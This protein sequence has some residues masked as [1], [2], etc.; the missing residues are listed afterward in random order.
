MNELKELFD[1]IKELDSRFKEVEDE[2]EKILFIILNIFYEF[3]LVGKDDIENVEV[4]C[5]GDVRV[6]DFEVKLYWEI[7]M[8]FGILDFERVLKVLGSCFIFYR[9]F[10]VR[11]E[12]VLINFMFDFY[13]EKYGYIEIFLFFLVVRKFMI[14]IG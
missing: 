11:L 14:G 5:W 9:G 7:G 3:V 4:R 13:I 1:K 8:S 12:R 6:F 2:I 10:G